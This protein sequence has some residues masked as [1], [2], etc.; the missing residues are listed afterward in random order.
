MTRVIHI[1]PLFLRRLRLYDLGDRFH[2][3]CQPRWIVQSRIVWCRCCGTRDIITWWWEKPWETIC[4]DCC[5]AG[6][7]HADE[8]TGHQFEH[9]GGGEHLCR[10]CGIPRNCTDWQPYDN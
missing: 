5:G 7:V 6:A 8:E 10:Y 3:T 9:Q 1:S 4:P 2:S